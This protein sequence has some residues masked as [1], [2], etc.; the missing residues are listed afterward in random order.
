MGKIIKVLLHKGSTYHIGR[1]LAEKITSEDQITEVFVPK[2]MSDFCCGC[3]NC[4]S[5]SETLCPHFSKMKPIT[6]LIDAS[7]VLIFT[8][9]VYV[10]SVTGSMKALLDHYGYRFMVHR[11]E[12]K[13]F[14]KQA[15]CIATAAGG[16]MKSACDV[17]K[18][19]MFYWG[20]AKTYTYGIAVRAVSWDG[21]T[22]KKKSQ[23]ENATDNLAKKILN[24]KVK[25]SLRTKLFFNIMRLVQKNGWNP[26]DQQYWQEKGWL[27]DKRPWK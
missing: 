10:L 23:I 24:R 17:I 6:D 4:F 12:E 19:S 13:M 1:M 20:I 15:V 16:G 22:Q 7:D 25:P 5:K 2:D 27:E 9:P 21:V 11:P 8:S 3:I 14:S 26:V 18:G